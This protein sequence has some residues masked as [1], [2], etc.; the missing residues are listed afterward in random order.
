MAGVVSEGCGVGLFR[1]ADQEDFSFLF[2][3]IG[4]SCLSSERWS[5]EALR[6]VEAA[7]RL[8]KHWVSSG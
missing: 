8:E 3:P 5:P 1:S 7:R 2:C 4:E 6:W